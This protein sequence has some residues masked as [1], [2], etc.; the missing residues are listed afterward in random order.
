[1]KIAL[2]LLMALVGQC[3]DT[4]KGMTLSQARDLRTELFT[5]DVDSRYFDFAI[6]EVG[7]WIEIV[8]HAE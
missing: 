7:K 5:C 1:M 4:E 2:V 6:S 3:L 8:E